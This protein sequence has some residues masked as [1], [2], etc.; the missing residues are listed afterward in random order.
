M[1]LNVLNPLEQ[2]NRLTRA[3]ANDARQQM[4]SSTDLEIRG[5]DSFRQEMLRLNP[6]T[7]RKVVGFA[8]LR[9]TYLSL[10]HKEFPMITSITDFASKEL[11]P[12]NQMSG[13]EDA[14]QKTFSKVRKEY[15]L[16]DTFEIPVGNLSGSLAVV[17]GFSKRFSRSE[18]SIDPHKALHQFRLDKV[19][20][21]PDNSLVWSSNFGLSSASE[22]GD[23]GN[24]RS[25]CNDLDDL[26]MRMLA[27]SSAKVI[28][29]CGEYTQQLI[30]NNAKRLETFEPY[31]MRLSHQEVS[32]S[33]D[34][35]KDQL[36]RI[37]I[38]APELF[39]VLYGDGWVRRRKMSICLKL[40]A[41]L[42]ETEN[43]NHRF[44]ETANARAAVF[45]AIIRERGGGTITPASIEGTAKD[46]LCRQGFESSQDLTELADINS[47]M[48]G[49]SLHMLLFVLRTT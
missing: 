45:D 27:A 41:M 11:Q 48:L 10:M 14:C 8:E 4:N 13:V 5:W 26:T 35:H 44:Y 23:S 12:R 46:W 25:L 34:V 15:R 3:E 33:F 43:L 47:G 39:D 28:V 49:R 2:G 37:Y 6:R 20:L 7:D 24:F 38:H 32:I 36:R 21:T 42:L 17:Y 29:V 31:Q 30:Q 1:H 40:A 22:I 18:A 16:D 9:A 19:G